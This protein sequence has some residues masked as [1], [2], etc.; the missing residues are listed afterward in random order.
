M[1]TVLE[2]VGTYIDTS[3]ADLTLG[4]NLFLSKMP[5]SPDF[6]VAI[7]EYEGLPPI[8]TFGSAGFVIERPSLQIMVRAARED[9]VTARDKAV[10]LRNL[11]AAIS[12]TSL[13]GI[14]IL[15]V[16]SMG[17]VN[18]LGVDELERPQVIFNVDCFVGA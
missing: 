14:G 12:N 8:E 13:S 3:S 4:T 6:C 18:P 16:T 10:T 15:R 2:A 7:F 5:E 17:S 11:I 9:Y 1:P